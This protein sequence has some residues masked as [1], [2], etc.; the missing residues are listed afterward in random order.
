MFVKNPTSSGEI[1]STDNVLIT[2]IYMINNKNE[3]ISL[4]EDQGR[5]FRHKGETLF[6]FLGD[7]T[8]KETHLIKYLLHL[9]KKHT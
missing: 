9:N 3:H 4:I 5:I 8:A 6:Q 2:H 1:K 7:S